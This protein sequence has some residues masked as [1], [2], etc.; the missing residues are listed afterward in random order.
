MGDRVFDIRYA[1]HVGSQLLLLCGLSEHSRA[2][3]SISALNCTVKRKSPS[4]LAHL[5]V[6]FIYAVLCCSAGAATC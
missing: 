1:A 6:T 3:H 4:V 5:R 2:N